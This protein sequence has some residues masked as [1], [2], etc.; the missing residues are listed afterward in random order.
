MCKLECSLHW[1]R[2]GKSQVHSPE[3]LVLSTP[4]SWYKYRL[5]VKLIHEF[6][7][8]DSWCQL[9][10]SFYIGQTR[11]QLHETTSYPGPFTSAQCARGEKRALY[12]TFTHVLNFFSSVN[13]VPL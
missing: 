10:R 5:F 8:L 3:H 7:Q 1:D 9:V 2:E 13:S 4:R 6:L 12:P 11:A